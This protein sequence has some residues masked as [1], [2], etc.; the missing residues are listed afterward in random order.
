MGDASGQLNDVAGRAGMDTGLCNF[1][2]QDDFSYSCWP[3]P[4]GL[5]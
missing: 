4:R 2:T 5:F 1:C 3:L